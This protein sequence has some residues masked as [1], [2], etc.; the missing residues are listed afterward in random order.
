M[1]HQSAWQ[2]ATEL[3]LGFQPFLITIDLEF[4][5]GQVCVYAASIGFAIEKGMKYGLGFLEFF[6][7]VWKGRHRSLKIGIDIFRAECLVGL[8]IGQVHIDK[9]QPCLGM[10]ILLPTDL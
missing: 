10:R 4:H 1:P 9:A 7:Q 6:L 3:S 5:P 8:F 2:G